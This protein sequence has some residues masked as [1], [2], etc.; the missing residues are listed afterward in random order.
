MNNELQQWHTRYDATWYT[1][2]Q[3]F[4]KEVSLSVYKFR[5]PVFLVVAEID[6]RK[7]FLLK[8]SF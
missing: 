4:G 2:K 7:Y 3:A 6:L 8:T 5:Q 1:S